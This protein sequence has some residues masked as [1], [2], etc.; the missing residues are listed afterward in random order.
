MPDLYIITGP[1]GAGKSTISKKIAKLKNKSVLIEGDDIYHQIVGGYVQAWKKGNHLQTFWKIC[2]NTIKIYLE[3]G[4]DVVFNYI[5]TPK[6]LEIIKTQFI[7]YTIKFVV[8]LVDENTLLLRDQERP[9]DCQMKER[10]ITLLNSFKN[11]NYNEKNI[12]NTT[13]LSIDETVN[14]IKMLI[15]LFCRRPIMIIE[16]DSH[17]DEQIK[18]LL[19]ELQNYLIDIDDWHTQVMLPEYRE[20][21]FKMDMEKVKKQY[22]KIYLAMENDMVIGL[23]M[24]IVEEK[25][26]IDKLTNDCAKTG[27]V[28]EL[29]VKNNI[30]GN[31]IGKSLLEKIEKY[32]KSIDC[33]RI[34]IEVFGPN[35]KGLNFYQKNNYIVRD[36]IVSKKL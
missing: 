34:N 6:N 3:D 7:K 20:N 9:A 23:V 10:C 1:A 12:L 4:F 29:I 19:V 28:I 14:I 25:D 22:G 16:F 18:N 5:V 27:S 8:L 13:N 30:R 33:K 35:K 24:G 32:F 21:N 11:N 15:N 2:I 31:G 36:M 17:Y 26:E